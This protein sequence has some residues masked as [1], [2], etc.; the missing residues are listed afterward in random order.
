MSVQDEKEAGFIVII[1]MVAVLGLV[2]AYHFKLISNMKAIENKY[3]AKMA[4]SDAN[5]LSRFL[6]N[7]D[8][9]KVKDN[10]PDGEN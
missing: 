7:N 4:A 6:K 5:H 3:E 10:L 2:S 9:N 8:A 1:I